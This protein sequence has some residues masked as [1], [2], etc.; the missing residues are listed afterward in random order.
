VLVFLKQYQY[1]EYIRTPLTAHYTLAW[2]SALCSIQYLLFVAAPI[3][4]YLQQHSAFCRHKRSGAELPIFFDGDV[5]TP[6]LR[7][8]LHTKNKHPTATNKLKHQAPSTHTLL[9]KLTLLAH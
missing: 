6:L 9:V 4:C 3:I 5:Y 2:C 7:S 1:P 8:S